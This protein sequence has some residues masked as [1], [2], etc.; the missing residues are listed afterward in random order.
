[1]GSQRVR[2]DLETIVCNSTDLTGTVRAGETIH[3]E[4]SITL[5]E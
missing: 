4:F 1:M 3:V 2:H 5:T